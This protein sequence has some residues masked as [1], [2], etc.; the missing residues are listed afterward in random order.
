MKYF[1]KTILIKLTSSAGKS[2]VHNAEHHTLFYFCK[3][4][5]KDNNIVLSGIESESQLVKEL[6]S[7]G[8]IIRKPLFL[9]LI[10]I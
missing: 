3:W 7:L 10:H 4:L 6:K 9:S 2:M 8:V 5:I 1:K